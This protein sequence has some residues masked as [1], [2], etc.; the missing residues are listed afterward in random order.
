MIRPATAADP[1]EAEAFLAAHPG[2]AFVDLMFTNLTGVAR[3]K[4]LRRHEVAAAYAQ[5][6]YLPGSV[7]MVDI[8]GLDVGESGMI[9]ADGDADRLAWPVPGSLA[10]SPWQ[11]PDSA[12]ALLAM[13]ELDGRSCALDPR[14]VL[15]RVLDRFAADGLTAVVACEL[16][17]YLIDAA[18]TADGGIQPAPGADGRRPPHSQVYGLAELDGADAFLRALWAA[19]DAMGVPAGAAIAEYAPGQFEMTLAHRADALAACDDA[20]RFKHAAK[21]CAAALGRAA[22]FMAKPFA[23][24]SGSGLHLHVS[25]ADGRG[26]NLFAAESLSGT[27]ALRH[28]IGGVTAGIADGM[29]IFAPNANSYR[30]FR[31]NSYAPVRAGWGLN[32]RTVPV[33]V[34]AGP[35]AARRFEH[36][37]SGADANPYLA[38]AAV[39]AGVHDGLTRRA[40]PGPPTVGDGYGDGEAPSR[41][42]RLPTDWAYAIERLA[43]SALLIDYLGAEAVE[44]LT[45]IKRVEHERYSAVVTAL[46]YDWVLRSA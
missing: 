46:D 9:F 38:V 20:V 8:T 12:T 2:V 13:H 24:R 3:G 15:G 7:L 44:M 34:P 37:V 40:D 25:V 41:G 1:A 33:R 30:R 19:C 4:R 17:F 14:A 10:L 36:R 45:T 31:P 5:G 11:G 39:L 22:T 18:R 42:E 16:E 28:A 21:G 26:R 27:P 35:A 29:A 23:D 6:R 32:N 43:R